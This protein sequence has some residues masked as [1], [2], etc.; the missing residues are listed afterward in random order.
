MRY[1]L[2]GGNYVVRD[3]Q[4]LPETRLGRAIRGAV[5]R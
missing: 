3:G 2:V 4:L 1:V 5:T